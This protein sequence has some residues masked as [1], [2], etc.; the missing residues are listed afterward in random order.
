MTDKNRLLLKI[1]A[2]L[3]V[4]WGL[5]HMFAGIMTMSQET[6]G[7]VAGIADA[8]D[9][10]LLSGEYH[11]AVGAILEPESKVLLCIAMPCQSACQEADTGNERPGC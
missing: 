4:I 11:P 7:A 10:A 6:A 8:V 2:V 9:P 3:W 5:V 1:S